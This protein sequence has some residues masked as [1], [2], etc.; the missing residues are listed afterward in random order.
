MIWF[1]R[2]VCV[3]TLL[4]M[5][6]SLVHDVRVVLNP[7]VSF[8][9][10]LKDGTTPLA[11]LANAL[12]FPP[13]AFLVYFCFFGKKEWQAR[14]ALIC[15][16][17][18]AAGPLALFVAALQMRLPGGHFDAE[19]IVSFLLLACLWS[20]IT[21]GAFLQWRRIRLRKYN[22]PF[23]CYGCQYD[24]TGNVSGR[25]PECGRNITTAARTLDTS[26]R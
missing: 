24:L 14:A 12:L 25:C 9:T 2:I 21:L 3:L 5:T 6:T 26:P 1:S 4:M 7:S 20:G 23:R 17:F 15:A 16:L 18:T 8:A 11:A 22:D 10:S 13:A 19:A